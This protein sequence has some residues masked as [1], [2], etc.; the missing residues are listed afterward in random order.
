MMRISF[1]MLISPCMENWIRGKGQSK[2]NDHA[3][4]QEWTRNKK[5]KGP[6]SPDQ[7]SKPHH[8]ASAA[9]LPTICAQLFAFYLTK[10]LLWAPY[11]YDSHLQISYILGVDLRQI[12]IFLH[13]RSQY[14]LYI[15]TPISHT[16]KVQLFGMFSEETFIFFTLITLMLPC[17]LGNYVTQWR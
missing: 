12:I 5:Q 16:Y 17:L 4:G 6:E 11:A 2:N 15:C 9:T 10:K 8:T 13:F 3:I 1:D 14:L 7:L